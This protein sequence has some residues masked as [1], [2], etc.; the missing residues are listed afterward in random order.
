MLDDLKLIHQ[1]DPQDALGICA[2]QWEY[3]SRDFDATVTAREPIHNVVLAGM[4]GSALP[5][6]ILGSW[7]RLNVPFEITRTYGI[8]PY[9]GPNT[10]FISSSYSGNTEETLEALHHAEE[11]GAQIVVIAAGGKLADAAREKGYPLFAIPAGIQP[12]MA[13]FYFLNAFV[14][15][16]APLGLTIDNVEDL[17]V[18]AEWL[19]DELAKVAPDV[20]T[21]NNFAKQMAQELMGKTVIMYSGPLLFPAANKWKICFNENAKN[22]AWVNQYPEFNHNEFIGWSSHPVDKPFAVVEIRSSLEHPRVQRRFEVSERLLSGMRPAP[23]VVEPAGDTLLQ[24]LLWG[25]C[26]GDYVSVYLAIL[27]GVN[28]TPVDLVEKLKKELG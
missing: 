21:S 14:K 26:M 2:N 18:A 3:V 1:K 12:R 17:A 9:V 10:L 23:I 28:P 25:I 8:P 5:G 15:I 27:N 7:P 11:Q 22:T 16:L 13:T 24:Q 4:G 6:V 19:R 20:P